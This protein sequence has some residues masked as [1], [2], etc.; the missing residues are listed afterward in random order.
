MSVTPVTPD[1]HCIFCRIVRGELPSRKIYEDD[2][3]VAFW[4]ANPV[5]E[6]HILI[7]PKRHIPT[8]NDLPHE[9]T[10]LSHLG[11]VAQKVAADL[12]VDQSGYRFVINV[13]RG[14]G[15]VV[16]H[17]HAHLTAGNGV[18]LFLIRAAIGLAILWRKAVSL[19][20]RKGS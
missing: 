11:V 15:Q 18:G 20:W 3:V 17:L 13:N 2:R 10:L 1:P 19:V 14:G 9:D 4:D 5:A 16:F 6:V 12:G 7:V 8:L